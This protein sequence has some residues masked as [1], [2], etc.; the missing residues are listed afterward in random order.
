MI[1]DRKNK[2]KALRQPFDSTVEWHFHF[3]FQQNV[4]GGWGLA[5][6]HKQR[7]AKIATI[8]ATKPGT[9]RDARDSMKHCK[10]VTLRAGL[11]AYEA[12]FPLTG[13]KSII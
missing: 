8:G 3:C 4:Y 10:T 5:E 6:E 7:A 1:R 2:K 11:G 9:A 12:G 13:V